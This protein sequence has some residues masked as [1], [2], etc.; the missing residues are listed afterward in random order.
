[1]LN[2][3]PYKMAYSKVLDAANFLRFVPATNDPDAHA[4]IQ[5]LIGKY[6]P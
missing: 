6:S 1:M 2:N 3:G 4:G 5:C